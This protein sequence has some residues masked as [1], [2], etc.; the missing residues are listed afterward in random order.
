[1]DYDLNAEASALE[2][3][4]VIAAAELIKEYER[5]DSKPMPKNQHRLA[6]AVYALRRFRARGTNKEI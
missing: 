2:T 6:Q 5:V 1:M 4:V 3:L